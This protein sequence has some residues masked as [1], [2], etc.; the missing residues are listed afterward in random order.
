[1]IVLDASLAVDI[2][3]LTPNGERAFDEATSL[4]AAPELMDLEVLQV[5]RRLVL[6]D[7]NV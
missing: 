5:L 1:M 4:F 6:A 7:N 3:L 2:L